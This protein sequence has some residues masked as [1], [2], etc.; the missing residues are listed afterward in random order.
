MILYL[1]SKENLAIKAVKTLSSYEFK[2]DIDFGD[3]SSIVVAD[4]IQMEDGDYALIKDG[5]EQIFFG[6]C[7]EMKSS[8]TGYTVT[9][10]QKENLFDTT[11]FN[12]GEGLIQSAGMEDYI[13]KAIMDNFIASGD[14]LMDMDYIKVTARTHTK[15]AAR[16]S[17][18]V[19][20]ENGVY[21]LKTFLGNVR[22]NYGIFLGFTVSNGAMNIDITNREQATLNVDTKLPEISVISETYD[23]KVLAKLIVKWDVP[24]EYVTVDA[25][26]MAGT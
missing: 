1:L 12:D 20:A 25:L 13:A 17:T 8:D 14:T 6:I 10:R 24:K 2:E 11:I 3:S 5:E 21:N 26:N 9:L 4:Y 18:I 16:V 22:Q 19:D 15:V 7:Q 23:V